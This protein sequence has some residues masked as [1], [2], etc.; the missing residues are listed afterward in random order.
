[1]VNNA[2]G[3]EA[4]VRNIGIISRNNSVLSSMLSHL[5]SEG[6]SR[7]TEPRELRVLLQDTG[8]IARETGELLLS[9][10]SGATQN[11][12]PTRQRSMLAKLNQDFQ[13]VLRRFQQ[14]AEQA[15]KHA[16]KKPGGGS[17]GGGGGGGGGY[18]GDPLQDHDEVGD[19]ESAL[20]STQQQRQLARSSQEALAERERMIKQV[21]STVSEVN[22]IFVDLAGLVSEQ[23][24]HIGHISTMIENTSGAAHKAADELRVASNY[25]ARMRTRKCLCFMC[26]LLGAFFFIL[27]MSWNAE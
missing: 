24:E 21:E 13:F 22:E 6:G 10:Q 4:L 18:A 3:L 15:A 16:Q 25:A 12:L 11:E 2:Q 17:G 14:L 20:L 19:E 8:H 23:G 26:M 5:G 27:V 7:E 1:M 9:I